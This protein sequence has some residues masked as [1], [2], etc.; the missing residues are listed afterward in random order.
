MSRPFES[1]ST[2]VAAHIGKYADAVRIP[3]GAEIV[4]TSGTPGLRKDGTLPK[5]FT[6]EAI[7]AW[8]NVEEALQRAG[9]A[10]TDIVSVRQWLTDA[11]DIPAYAAVRSSVIR[12]EP[13]FMLAVV[14]ALVWPDIRV[15]VEV[16]AIRRPAML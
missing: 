8:R 6:D 10:L 9:T 4:Y 3:A 14:P 12:H 13:V 15:E 5:D 7:Q 16:T 11:A 2:G 1:I